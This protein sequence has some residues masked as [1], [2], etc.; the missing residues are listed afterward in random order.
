MKHKILLLTIFL[1]IGFTSQQCDS[2]VCNCPDIETPF[3]DVIGLNL[4][5]LFAGGADLPI[6]FADYTGV[7]V[8]YDVDLIAQKSNNKC[9]QNSW[10]SFSL[11]NT[12]NA[13][14]CVG[15]GW[16]GSKEEKLEKIT[17][18]TLNDFDENHMAGDTINDFLMTQTWDT[19]E[20]VS[21]QNYLNTMEENIPWTAQKFFLSQAPTS[22]QKFKAKVIVE[23][24]TGEIYEAESSEVEIVQ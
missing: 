19:G 21:I 10:W 14:S 15:E 20:D 9:N 11:M 23:L 4:E 6:P 8:V 12:A 2:L 18:I 13:C 22:G 24:S 7:L 3:F 5:H 1:T 16:Q 17:F